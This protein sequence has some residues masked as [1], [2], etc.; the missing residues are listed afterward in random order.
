MTPEKYLKEFSNG[1]R[2]KTQASSQRSFDPS[3][4]YRFLHV[5]QVKLHMD[6]GCGVEFVDNSGILAVWDMTERGDGTN[7]L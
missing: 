3:N 1:G 5:I 7:N 6:G 4:L 2:A